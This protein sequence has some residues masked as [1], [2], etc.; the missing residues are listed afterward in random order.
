MKSIIDQV[1]Q[2]CLDQASAQGIVDKC[3]Q[4]KDLQEGLL[5]QLEK[6]PPQFKGH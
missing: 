4:S 2:G 5:A 3:W 1:A 6:R